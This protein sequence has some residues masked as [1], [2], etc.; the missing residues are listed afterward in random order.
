MDYKY[1]Y[2]IVSL[3][4]IT[5]TL[6][7]L[8]KQGLRY[9]Y[10]KI[11]KKYGIDG[12]DKKYNKFTAFFF[13]PEDLLKLDLET[14]KQIKQDFKRKHIINHNYLDNEFGKII[15]AD[16]I[17]THTARMI[18]I[19][20]EDPGLSKPWQSKI[21]NDRR[22]LLEALKSTMNKGLGFW[23]ALVHAQKNIPKGIDTDRG[24]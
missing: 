22:P 1:W 21:F 3:I 8:F 18:N 12:F 6:Y 2:L 9:R 13:K 24:I 10:T 20:D 11:Y 16:E 5:F 19:I 14:E 23:V 17:E 7:F 4:L 15:Y